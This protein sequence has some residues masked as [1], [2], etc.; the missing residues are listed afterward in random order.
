MIVDR[1]RA[2]GKVFGLTSTEATQAGNL[3]LDRCL[4]FDN[5]VLV[6]FDS[7][8]THSFISQECVSRLGLVVRDLGYELAVSTPASGQVLINLVCAGC[9]IEVAGHRFKLNLICFAVEGP[10]RNTWYGLDVGQSRHY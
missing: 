7:R 4:L 1:P 6:L 2:T 3:I 5:N 9:S 10:G 8:A